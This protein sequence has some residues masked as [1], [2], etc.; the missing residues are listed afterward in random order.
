MVN[1]DQQNEVDD[2][3]AM[4]DACQ[5]LE[6]VQWDPTDVLFFFTQ[7]ESKMKSSGVKN[8]FTKYSEEPDY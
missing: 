4:R 1:F 3:G 5:R 6:K 2:A 7:I 8:N